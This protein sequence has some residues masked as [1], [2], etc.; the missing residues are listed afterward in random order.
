MSG[1]G[2]YYKYRCKYWMTYNCPNWVWV[3]NAPCAHC[4]ADGREME[5]SAVAPFRSPREVCVPQFEKG[6]LYYVVMELSADGKIDGGWRL[7][8]QPKDGAP[9]ISTTMPITGSCEAFSGGSQHG[10][11]RGASGSKPSM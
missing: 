7:K 4:L 9:P 11:G 5:T 10:L 2:G 8:S 6:L 1:S 3:N